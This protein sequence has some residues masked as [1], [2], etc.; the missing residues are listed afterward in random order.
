MFCPDFGQKRLIIVVILLFVLLGVNFNSQPQLAQLL[1]GGAV[2]YLTGNGILPLLELAITD[3]LTALIPTVD[4]DD[5]SPTFHAH[6][7][8]LGNFEQL[9]DRAFS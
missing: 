6:N 5:I 7:Q 4:E 8:V 9:C 3:E 1:A 2:L